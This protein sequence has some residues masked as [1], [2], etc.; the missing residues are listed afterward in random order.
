MTNA[1]Q[2]LKK[3]TA[4]AVSYILGPITGVVFLVIDEDKFVRFHAMQSIVFSFAA[5]ILN[6]TLTLTVILSPLVPLLSILEF[7]L[8]LILI[9]TA[10]QGKKINLPIISKFSTKLIN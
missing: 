8:W 9:Y 1:K 2:S 4:A 7:I 6:T 10:S 5:M 3:E